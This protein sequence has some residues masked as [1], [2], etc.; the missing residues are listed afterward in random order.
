METIISTLD[1]AQR[2]LASHK[3]GLRRLQGMLTTSE[4]DSDAVLMVVFRH[5]LDSVL[6]F[7]K[8]EP[9]VERLAKFLTE[10]FATTSDYVLQTSI[11]FLIERSS[12]DDKNVRSRACQFI[13]NILATPNIDESALDALCETMVERLTPRLRDKFP[14]VR[15]WAIQAL[16]P[17]QNPEDEN[18]TVWN[19]ILRLM[20]SDTYFAVRVAATETICINKVTLPCIVNQIKDSKSEVRISALVYLS[21]NVDVRQYNSVMRNLLIQ[22][23]WNDRHNNDNVRLASRQ[24]ILGWLKNL[25]Y[26]VPKLLNLL[27]IAAYEEEAEE[28]AWQLIEAI[29]KNEFNCPELKEQ[30]RLS[31][32]NWEGSFSALSLGD[33]LW[34]KVRC[35]FAKKR[36][37]PFMAEEFLE[38]LVPDVVVLCDLISNGNNPSLNRNQSQQVVMKYLIA[39]TKFLDPADISGAEKLTFLCESLLDDVQFP[40]D[41]VYNVMDAWSRMKSP[42]T[43]LSRASNM[44]VNIRSATACPTNDAAAAVVDDAEHEEAREIEVYGYIRYLQILHWTFK[45]LF[46]NPDTRSIN[47]QESLGPEFFAQILED[48]INAFQQPIMELRSLAV[49]CLGLLGLFD[50]ELCD[51]YITTFY[52]AA[53][54][55]LEEPEIR[56]QALQIIVDF[57]MVYNCDFSPEINLC[58]LLARLHEDDD[59]EVARVSV[60]AASKLLFSGVL[61]DTRLLAILLKFFFVSDAMKVGN[62][63]EATCMQMSDIGNEHRLQQILSLFFQVFFKINPEGQAMLMNSLP[64]FVSDLLILIKDIGIPSNILEKVVEKLSILCEKVGI[65]KLGNAVGDTILRESKASIIACVCREML[66]LGSSKDDRQLCLDLL[67]CIE[68][69][70]VESFMVT[71]WCFD[72][73]RTFNAVLKSAPLDK[74]GE[75][76]IQRAI[77]MSGMQYATV[78]SNHSFFDLAPGLDHLVNM[79][80]PVPTKKSKGLFGLQNKSIN[81]MGATDRVR[82]GGVAD[83]TSMDSEDSDFS[84]GSQSSQSSQSSRFSQVSVSKFAAGVGK[85]SQLASENRRNTGFNDIPVMDI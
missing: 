11:Q 26:R 64:D 9:A 40:I 57:A 60:D 39:I 17:L 1:D 67:K 47:I 16:G 19:E 74:T 25:D 33:L 62:Q 15:S 8:K 22:Y 14:A 82:G 45:Q 68:K 18:D 63:E 56:S 65:L 36:L 3:T 30:S 76:I 77:E 24:L 79:V 4:G 46:E 85:M 51:Q 42:K 10:F 58:S 20:S 21:E 38:V 69:I 70:T 27:N 13:A 54:T 32:I 55:N 83:R 72:A 59:G 41:L 34:N 31:H 12:A 6:L 73:K 75:K 66:K 23:G 49:S 44:A 84:V 5:A 50:R 29:E 80:D 48:I 53:S 7:P 37:T 81:R 71:E 52:N 61:H 2:T 35:D 28:F 43:I 78:N